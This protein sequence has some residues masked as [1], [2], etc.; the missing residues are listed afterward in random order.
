MSKVRT[1][2]KPFDL[3]GNYVADFIEVSDDVISVGN[4][5]ISVDN[6]DF[7]VGIIKNSSLKLRLKN[8]DGK[9]SDVG[10]LSSIFGTKRKDTIVRVTW[11]RLDN[12]LICG[13]F[14][15]GNTP[16]G[17]ETIV[18]EGLLNDVSGVANIKDQNLDFVVL[19]YDSKLQEIEVPFGDL[20][21]TMDYEEIIL[22]CVDQA[23]FNTFVTVSAGN[24][25]CAVNHVVDSVDE[26]ENKTVL[27]AL[28]LLLS[29]SQSVLYINNDNE[30]IVSARTPSA[31]LK[32]TFYGQASIQGVENIIDIQTYR[33]G[34]N[35]V[36]NFWTWKDTTL[37]QSDATSVDRYGVQK[38]E[39]DSPLIDAASTSKINDILSAYRTDFKDPKVE[40][41]LVVPLELDTLGLNILDRINIDY[42]TVFEVVGD[43]VLPR[44]G[45]AVYGESRY[46]FARFNLIISTDTNF[47]ILGKKFSVTNNVVTYKIREI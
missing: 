47:K 30:L 18:F 29:N 31:S 20:D 15:P 46:G 21:A 41:Q 6:S 17:S 44:Y 9:Y 33:D 8:D 36:K 11:D 37:K 2:I 7:E 14:Q 28:K 39:L 16:L 27:E 34:V 23:P 40:M 35:R 43:S 26:L 5:E 42:P 22:A 25:N 13:F 10:N 1:Y 38:V 24:I 4:V 32:K 45:L 12:P 3:S 19:G